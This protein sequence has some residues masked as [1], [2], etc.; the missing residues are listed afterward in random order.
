VALALKL[1]EVELMRGE[2]GET[3]VL[4]LDDILS[5]LDERRGRHVLETV[6]AAEQVLMTTTDLRGFTPEFVRRAMLWTVAA[7]AV[8]ASGEADVDVSAPSA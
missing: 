3:P 5:E 1:A 6:S 4:L 2:T 7:G 8:E